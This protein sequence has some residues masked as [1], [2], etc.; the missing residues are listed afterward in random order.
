[1]N[2]RRLILSVILMTAFGL[3]PAYANSGIAFGPYMQRVSEKAAT[4]LIRTD[5]AEGIILQYRKV[6]AENWKEMSED[7]VD[8]VHRFRL[9]S[10]K[11]GQYYEY[12]FKRGG[13]RLTQTYTFQTEKD[14]TKDDPLRVAVVGDFGEMTTDQLRVLTY[15][16]LWNP[17]IVLTTG[18]NAYESGTLEEFQVNV[19]KPY[20]PLLAE[21]PMYAS[22]GNHDM[23]TENAVPYKSVFE[24]P[25]ANSDS[26]DY[27]SFNYDNIHF[28]SINSDIDY[29]VGSEQYVWLENDLAESE[30]RWNIVFFHHPVYSSGEHGSTGDMVDTIVPLFETYNVDLVLNGHDHNYERNRRVNGVLYLVTGGGGR[31]LYDLVAPTEVSEVFLSEF[32][33]TGLTINNSELAI[34]AIDKRGYRFDHKTLQHD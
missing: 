34:D 16:M 30:G 26:E 13:D 23:Y 21:V 24:L 2:I 29:S 22:I 10:L 4:I 1:M 9:T 19:F 6:G 3:T 25:Q 20:G 14:V 18:D 7:E 8:T 5:V 32:H 28:T 15:M 27:Y 31:A 12:Y 17:D 11:Q 33:F